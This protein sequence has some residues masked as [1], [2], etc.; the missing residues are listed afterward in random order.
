MIILYL[1]QAGYSSRY[2]IRLGLIGLSEVIWRG[3]VSGRTSGSGI[4]YRLLGDGE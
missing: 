3:L 2:S 1:L 4:L